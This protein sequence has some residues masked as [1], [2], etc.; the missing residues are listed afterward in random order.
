MLYLYYIFFA[1]ITVCIA[2]NN[3]KIDR[4]FKEFC[5]RIQLYFHQKRLKCLS[6]SKIIL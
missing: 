2:Q 4:L 3:Y 5:E 1:Y 6:K